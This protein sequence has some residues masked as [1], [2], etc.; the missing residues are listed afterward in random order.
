[1]VMDSS[2]LPLAIHKMDPG[3]NLRPKPGKKVETT[4]L[5]ETITQ[6]LN[7]QWDPVH[8]CILQAESTLIGRVLNDFPLYNLMATTQ[9]PTT[10]TTSAIANKP[11]PEA[12]IQADQHATTG[13]QST[14][15]SDSLSNSMLSQGMWFTTTTTQLDALTMRQ[16][17]LKTQMTTQLTTNSKPFK[18]WWKSNERWQDSYNNYDSYD[19]DRPFTPDQSNMEEDNYKTT[20]DML[21]PWATGDSQMKDASSLK[22]QEET[23][24]KAEGHEYRSR[25]T[26]WYLTTL[27]RNWIRIV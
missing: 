12:Q 11:L 20:N 27:Q 16:N 13:A 14:N 15:D 8:N 10:V 21:A 1:M 7:W 19:R 24:H 23:E 6:Q 2:L 18:T 4:F 3:A 22:H 5:V 17:K 26:T 25:I 9:L